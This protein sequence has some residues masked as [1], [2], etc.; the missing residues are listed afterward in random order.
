MINSPSREEAG[1]RDASPA[2]D[3]DSLNLGY[4]VRALKN[5]P[6]FSSGEIHGR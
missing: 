3:H 4:I 5:A 1:D 6:H 2:R